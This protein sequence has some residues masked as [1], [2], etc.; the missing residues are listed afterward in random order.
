MPQPTVTAKDLDDWSPRLD[1]RAHLPTLIR[2]L[3][4]AS[5]RP[6]QIVVPDAE[7]TGLP[8]LDGIVFSAAGA[9]PY[10]PGG[11]S[12]W[13]FKTSADAQ[14]ELGK[15][16]RKR[17]RQLSDANRAR[18]TI[19]LVTTRIWEREKVERWIARRAGDG[20]AEIRVIAAEDL[21]TWLAQ[22]PGVLG[23][24]E[25][26]C[27]RNPYGRTAVRDWWLRWS[28]ATEPPIP[29]ALLL[30]G[31]QAERD[32]LLAHLAGAASDRVIAAGSEEEA[33]AFLAATLL[34][35]RP[36]MP[37]DDGE[38]TI[39]EE[40]ASHATKEASW[41]EA[42]LERTIVV[43]DTNAWRSLASHH[44]PLILLPTASCEPTIDAAV[45]AG[46]HVVLPRYAPP[47]DEGL[48]RLART[49]A[50]EA[51]EQLGVPWNESDEL[52]RAARRSLTSLRRRR[53]RA[54]HLR[55]PDWSSGTSSTLLVVRR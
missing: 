45:W 19:V 9:P 4:F 12:A 5:V 6:D 38:E 26:H 22:C 27:G 37:A 24:L 23:W 14:R 13:E 54:G 36:L 11:R 49:E 43:H 7:G 1:A 20:W 34:V 18:T 3:L 33:I 30:A 47:G 16:Y 46:H 29:P 42:I 41:R 31:R 15:D 50:R 17:T 44:E 35:P 2:R 10:V 53:G 39:E 28:N 8:G 25:E 32:H 48:P 51:W 52:A 40:K 55:R 21:A